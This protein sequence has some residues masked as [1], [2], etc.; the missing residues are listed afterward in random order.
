MLG[1]ISSSLIMG[2]M[3]VVKDTVDISLLLIM[4]QGLCSKEHSGSVGAYW[5]AWH[6]S[7]SL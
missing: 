5:I 3:F 2:S 4:Y 1:G 7:S 6:Q